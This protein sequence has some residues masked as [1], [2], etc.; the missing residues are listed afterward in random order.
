MESYK[1]VNATAMSA[2]LTSPQ[3]INVCSLHGNPQLDM[4]TQG[5]VTSSPPGMPFGPLVCLIGFLATTTVYASQ[6]VPSM[7]SLP[8]LY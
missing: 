1:F 2:P 6:K 7:E 3:N 8:I 5:R 4:N